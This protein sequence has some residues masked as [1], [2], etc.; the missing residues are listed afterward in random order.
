MGVLLAFSTPIGNRM[1]TFTQQQI[2]ELIGTSGVLDLDVDDDNYG[3]YVFHYR[4]AGS[5]DDIKTYKTTLR[6]GEDCLV[7]SF[8]EKGYQMKLNN[9][10]DVP[11]VVKIEG[12]LTE[13]FIKLIPETYSLAFELNGGYWKGG[14]T[15]RTA[16]TY[17][18]IYKFPETVV[19][20][21]YKFVGWYED[22]GLG[23]IA[24]HQIEEDDFGN[25]VFYA[26]YSVL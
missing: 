12:K 2:D 24:K 3:T 8:T 10:K 7:P 19:K 17:G 13:M 15:V 9:G 14:T 6:I 23:G 5:S 1:M 22:S 16:Y 20:E 25:K 26:K 11:S 21:D 18:T 4:V